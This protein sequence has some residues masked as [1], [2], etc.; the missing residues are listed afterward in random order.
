[1]LSDA[2][3][4]QL[5]ATLA[6]PDTAPSVADG[7][8][9]GDP[10]ASGSAAANSVDPAPAT[11][12]G[13]GDDSD[14]AILL[15][16]SPLLADDAN[17]ADRHEQQHLDAV[18]QRREL[19]RRELLDKIKLP[20]SYWSNSAKEDRALHYVDNFRR[21][22]QTLFPHRK[23]LFLTPENE[24]GVKKCVCTTIRPSQ[25]GLKDLYG[26]RSCARFVADYVA[27]EPLDPP[28]ELPTKLASPTHTLAMQSGNAFDM[29][30]LL[31][32]LLRG[33]G[34]EALVVSGYA[35]RQ[36][37]LM[38]E[39]H[40]D[41]DIQ[42]LMKEWEFDVPAPATDPGHDDTAAATAA[43][44]TRP[45]ES[46]PS[47]AA[48]G[49]YKVKSKQPLNSRFLAV[50]EAKKEAEAKKLEQAKREQMQT[51][52]EANEHDDEMAGLRIHAWVLVLPGKRDI[53]EAFFI[54]ASTG[55][56]YSLN[57]PK[58]LGVESVF[59]STNYWVNMQKC[60]NGLMARSDLCVGISFDLADTTKWEFVFLQNPQ[61][62]LAAS[63][64]GTGA[65]GSSTNPVA[66]GAPGS[67]PAGAEE[68]EDDG[69]AGDGDSE[70]FDLPPSWVAKLD[71]SPAQ[72]DSRC[73]SG[74]KVMTWRNVK[75]EIFATYHR[76]DGMVARL[77]IFSDPARGVTGELHEKFA[78]R[79]DKL[80]KRTRIPSRGLLHEFFERGRAHALQEHVMEHG[81]TVRM[82]FFRGARADGLYDRQ[83][84]ARKIIDRFE[85]REDRLVYRS[86]THELAVDADDEL[87]APGDDA[88]A[89]DARSG[90]VTIVKMTEK[91]ARRPGPPERDPTE[92]DR[93]IY[94]RSFLVRDEKIRVVYHTDSGCLIPAWREFRKPSTE[95]KTSFMDLTTAFETRLT[96]TVLK[97]QH[98]YAKLCE[99]LKAEQACLH[100]VKASDREVKEIL[101]SRQTEERSIQLV[102]SL[103]DTIRNKTVR[104]F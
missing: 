31:C 19:K 86:V 17:D 75:L 6:G 43:P 10:L 91:Y 40:V 7:T 87:G 27:Y 29:S 44:T 90:A 84:S 23:D 63:A 70:L 98:L 80:A 4:A 22:Y 24:F 51:Q 92:D 68:E 35:A 69:D 76:P 45:D 62:L 61:P 55:K 18:Q 102:V 11:L 42:R 13:G 32:S 36:I 1:M 82:R 96:P 52:L 74:S 65:G 81:H 2:V 78:N 93:D 33:V 8:A 101:M 104:L 39:T 94:K 49:K 60:S 89:A 21:Q 66:S 54:E 48:E 103:F 99:L 83:E 47:A 53:A 15:A 50:M 79:K 41:T 97:K 71:L 34:F 14:D 64:N 85:D 100:A 30:V 67:A 12:V 77:T 28:F 3:D 88:A 16:T 38:D 46:T 95:Q 25:L 59:S 56:I 20:A 26:Y 57:D 72:F 5:P 73:P 58:Y 37:T 9:L